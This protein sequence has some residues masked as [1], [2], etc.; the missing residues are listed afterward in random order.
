M[1]REKILEEGMRVIHER[2]FSNATVRDITT[3]AQVP[4]GSFTNHFA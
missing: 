3:A 2:G 4:N 1:H